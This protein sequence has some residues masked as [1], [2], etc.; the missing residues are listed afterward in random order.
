MVGAAVVGV[1]AQRLVKRVCE[2][3]KQKYRPKQA[4][5][6]PLQK[7]LPKNAQFYKGAG[8]DYCNMTGYKGRTLI[9]EIFEINDELSSMIAKG[10]DVDDLEKMAKKYGY[11][12]MFIDGL[13]KA[14]RGETTLEEIYRVSRL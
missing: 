11:Q 13:R 6:E 12:N 1:E 5:L 10:A 3:C 4:L 8:C 14:L 2:H 7:I 9:T